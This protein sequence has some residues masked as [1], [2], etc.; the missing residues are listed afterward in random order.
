M[1]ET[2]LENFGVVHL[3][4]LYSVLY[5][6]MNNAFFFVVIVAIG[7]LIKLDLEYDNE[8]FVQDERTVT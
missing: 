4:A 8:E 5:F 6:L 2:I 1:I 7:Y 3:N